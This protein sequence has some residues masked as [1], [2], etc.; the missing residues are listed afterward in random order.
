MP[1]AQGRGRG[2]E[3]KAARQHARHA[4][5]SRSCHAAGRACLAWPGSTDTCMANQPIRDSLNNKQGEPAKT[6]SLTLLSS[7]RKG[8]LVMTNG[9]AQLPLPAAPDGGG[10]EGTGFGGGGDGDRAGE[11]EGEG[12]APPPVPAD[13]LRR[14]RG[15][16]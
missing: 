7:L 11:G 8:V 5:G 3:W 1:A 15:G 2:E 10:G 12:V 13:R 16:L 9:S 6:S 14:R 4:L